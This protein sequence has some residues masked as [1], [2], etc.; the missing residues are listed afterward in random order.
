MEINLPCVVIAPNKKKVYKSYI[1]CQERI[2]SCRVLFHT[3][4][5]RFTPDT[6][7]I[8]TPHF[9]GQFALSLGKQ[10]PYIFS[11][12][13]PLDTDTPLIRTL[14]M[15]P[16]VSVLTEFDRVLCTWHCTGTLI[17]QGPLYNMTPWII[18]VF[19][20]F[21]ISW[22]YHQV[23]LKTYTVSNISGKSNR[24]PRVINCFHCQPFYEKRKP[25]VRP[26]YSTVTQ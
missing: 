10:S 7:L 13:N 17:M 14:S 20:H 15:V 6:C 9:Y 25:V 26:F 19:W 8:Q 12:S 1:G 3:V 2:L 18:P 21:P 11:K 22:L 23:D 24:E 16:L 5:T 4:K